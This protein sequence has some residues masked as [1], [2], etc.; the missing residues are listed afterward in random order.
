PSWRYGC[1]G[2]IGFSFSVLPSLPS[3]CALTQLRIDCSGTPTSRA[4]LLT[5]SPPR[6]RRNA[7][8]LNSSVYA[9][10]GILFIEHLRQRYYPALLSVPDNRWEAQSNATRTASTPELLRRKYLD[11]C[12][13][14]SGIDTRSALPTASCYNEAPDPGRA[15]QL[16]F[17]IRTACVC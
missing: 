3:T 13:C 7:S 8:S 12:H 9:A 5:G 14:C 15:T 6:T 10:F 1:S 16:E 2:V 4:I 11:C 17:S